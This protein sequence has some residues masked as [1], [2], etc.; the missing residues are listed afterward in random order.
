MSSINSLTHLQENNIGRSGGG[1]IS[2]AYSQAS[3]L[4]SPQPK[5]LVPTI[6]SSS[7]SLTGSHPIDTA[8]ELI[9]VNF[10]ST[11]LSPKRK[12]AR[13]ADAEK[14]AQGESFSRNHN[15]SHIQQQQQQQSQMPPLRVVETHLGQSNH[16][17]LPQT[18]TS[19]NKTSIVTNEE[20]KLIDELAELDTRMLK[21]K[22]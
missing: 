19:S 11:G 4:T 22:Y 9:T 18:I 8:A 12:L 1:T 5:Q 13:V 10:V 2:R 16:R 17:L 20:K 15:T 6:T 21:K 14:I 7:S 3:S